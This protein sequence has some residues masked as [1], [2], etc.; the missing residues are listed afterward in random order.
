[1]KRCPITYEMIN[2]HENYS[3]RGLHLLSPQLKNL[4][5]LEFSAIE[6]RTEALARAGKCRFKACKAN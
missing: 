2:E 4:L 6:Q 5:P 3:Q 1:M